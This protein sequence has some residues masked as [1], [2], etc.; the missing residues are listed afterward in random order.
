M[1]DRCSAGRR[2]AVERRPGIPGHV[3]CECGEAPADTYAN[4]DRYAHADTNRD[5]YSIAHTD[6]YSCADAHPG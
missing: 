4:A 6:A 5:A 3:R 1:A 2:G